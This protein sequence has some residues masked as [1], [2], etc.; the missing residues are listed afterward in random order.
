[1]AGILS[2]VGTPIGN[3]SDASPRC[4][5]TLRAAQLICCEDTRVTSKLLARYGIEVPLARMDENVIAE[6]AAGIVERIAAGERVVFVSDAGMPC[7]SDPGQRLVDVVLDAGLPV[8]VIPGPTAVA[9]AIAASGLRAGR[10]FFEGFL[11]RKSGERIRRLEALAA[12]PG[13][14]VFYESP[15]R[16]ASALADIARVMPERRV[17]LARELTKVHEELVRG[18]AVELAEAVGERERIKGEC[19]IVVE[20]SD[21]HAAPIAQAPAASLEENIREGLAAGEAKTP[22]AKRLARL[23]GIA[24]SEVYDAIVRIAGE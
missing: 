11:P 22:L 20:E 19:V 21:P 9:S 24:R 4:L 2:V 15:L 6:R 18:S 16:I 12:I 10:F 3:L 5:E 17:A 7:I 13:A 23:H 8:E 1:M 14:L